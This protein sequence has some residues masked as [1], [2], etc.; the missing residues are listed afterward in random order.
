MTTDA[1]TITCVHAGRQAAWGA[2]GVR[3]GADGKSCTR[4]ACPHPPQRKPPIR[5]DPRLNDAPPRT[6]PDRTMSG[7]THRLLRRRVV[8]AAGAK[9]RAPA[10][11]LLKEEVGL[12]VRETCAEGGNAIGGRAKGATPPASARTCM[13]PR[14]T[15]GLTRRRRCHRCRAPVVE[16]GRPVGRPRGTLK[17]VA[18]RLRN[19]LRQLTGRPGGPILAVGLLLNKG[20]CLDRN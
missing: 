20:L 13:A 19:G 1:G 10:P 12:Q 18:S 6:P 8:V 14:L 11:G 4:L 9:R 15:S 3:Q 7:R 2:A 17:F 5:P 16:R